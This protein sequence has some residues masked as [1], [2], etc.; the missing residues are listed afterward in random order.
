MTLI[1]SSSRLGAAFLMGDTLL[2]YNNNTISSRIELPSQFLPGSEIGARGIADLMQK[3][4]ILDQT[5]AVGWSGGLIE[6]TE[7]IRELDRRMTYPFSPDAMAALQADAEMRR[8]FGEVSIV[9]L[10]IF[11]RDPM[12][13]QARSMVGGW[14]AEEWLPQ[15]PDAPKVFT[16]GSGAYHFMNYLNAGPTTFSREG[17]PGF[18]PTPLEADVGYFANRFAAVVLREA[19]DETSLNFFY[20][21]AFE[22][23]LLGDEGR[24]EKVPYCLVWW[25]LEG[26]KLTLRG[27]AIVANYDSE[28]AFVIRRAHLADTE[29]NRDTEFKVLASIPEFSARNVTATKPSLY[30]HAIKGPDTTRIVLGMESEHE[31]RLTL[32]EKTGRPH[33]TISR[34]FAN[35]LRRETGTNEL[36]IAGTDRRVVTLI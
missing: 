15:T 7:A 16:G 27:P 32:N 22:L 14:N 23:V 5:F 2:T 10:G 31:F 28:G 36:A 6:A 18:L 25:V 4:M 21:G 19:F 34:S 20:G 3:V 33:F 1:F 24:L 35:Y 26:Q 13:K 17:E 8:T 29:L 12:Q 11:D 9:F 30:V